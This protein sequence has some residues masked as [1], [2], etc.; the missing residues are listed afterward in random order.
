[1]EK[2]AEE[3]AKQFEEEGANYSKE[4]RTDPNGNKIIILK[5]DT[6][7][8]LKKVSTKKTLIIKMPKDTRTEVNVRYGELK[9]ADAHNLRATLNYSPFVAN[10]I[11][12]GQTLIN[13]AYG[14]VTV[15]NWSDGRLMLKFID[16]CVINQA[17][18]IEL[19]SNSSNVQVNRLEKMANMSGSFGDIQINGVA[20]DFD[21]ITLELDNS[22]AFILLPQS[23]FDFDFSGLRS[24]VLYPG[25]MS[26]DQ[27][28]QNGLVLLKGYNNRKNNDRRFVI[29]AKY[30][31]VKLQ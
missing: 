2:W 6:S 7:G 26:L 5:G 17:N 30:S 27:S 12:G 25:S 22:D 14:P 13:A 31:N 20:A 23:S 28:K 10:R 4:V 9:M 3:F 29:R 16:K 19:R 11:D 24:T 15:N 21:S 18:R 1:M 8:S